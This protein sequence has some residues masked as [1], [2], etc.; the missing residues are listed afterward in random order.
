MLVATN[1]VYKKGSGPNFETQYFDGNLDDFKNSLRKKYY[2]INSSTEIK[3]GFI[4]KQINIKD[5]VTV[6]ETLWK[7]T[8]DECAF[9][10]CERCGSS[11]KER[12]TYPFCVEINVLTIYDSE[13]N[14]KFGRQYKPD[15]LFNVIE[16]DKNCQNKNLRVGGVIPIFPPFKSCEKFGKYMDGAFLDIEGVKLVSEKIGSE[17]KSYIVDF[18]FCVRETNNVKVG[19]NW[20]CDEYADVATDY[21]R[22]KTAVLELELA[23]KSVTRNRCQRCKNWY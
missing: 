14:L 10:R 3:N 18:E 4:G 11:E 21:Y 5:G 15:D 19:Y 23:K 7:I 8:I 16:E 6:V 13:E 1:K 20:G 12:L 2:M 22:K 9:V 17:M